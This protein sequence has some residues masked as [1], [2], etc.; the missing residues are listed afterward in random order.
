MHT[1]LIWFRNDLRICDNTAL[2]HACLSKTDKVIGLF[3]FTPKQWNRHYISIRKI[4]FLHQHVKFL[5]D[6]L[7]K[8]NINLYH[9]ECTDFLNSI[10]YLS[11]FCKLNKVSRVFFNYQYE[12]NEKNRDSLVTQEL[13]AQGVFIEGFHDN[14]LIDPNK[15]KNKNN[16]PYKKFFFFKKQ[17]IDY[18]YK[19]IPICFPAPTKRIYHQHDILPIYLNKNDNINFDKNLFPIGEKEAINRIRDFYDNKIQYYFAKRNFPYLNNTSMLSPYLSLGII[20]IRYCLKMLLTKYQYQP[21]AA[22]LNSCWINEIIWREFYYHLLI[23]FPILSKSQSLL[24]WEKKIH[25]ENDMNYFDAWKN[26]KTGF[27]IIDAAMNQLNTTGWMHNRLRMITSSFLVKN[28]LIDWREGEKYFMSSLIDGDYALNNGG[29]QW[30][31]SIGSDSTSYIR[32]FNPLRQS[33]KFDKSGFFIKKYLPELKMIPNS[34]I[35]NPY[36][37][38]VQNNCKTN[39]PEPIINHEYRKKNFLLIYKRAKL[40]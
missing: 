36:E 11:Y 29:W 19:N 37:W 7:L 12:I 14:I 8:L 10:E 27:P 17:V 2:Y 5:Q 15:I 16:Q 39:Y 21:L 26:G 31:A 1:N 4:S 18:L 34:Y 33:K 30:S 22:I 28:L 13:S 35:H 23:N 20:S 38:I 9:H 32:I 24:K 3:I 40:L 6:E 25:W